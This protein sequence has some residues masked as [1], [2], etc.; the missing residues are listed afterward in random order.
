VFPDLI[1]REVEFC[2]VESENAP[3]L[4]LK[5]SHESKSREVVNQ[6]RCKPTTGTKLSTV[7]DW[8]LPRPLTM[9]TEKPA[10]A[11]AFFLACC[12]DRTCREA[13][14]GPG[15]SKESA[16]LFFDKKRATAG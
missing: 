4:R 3:E 12:R 10:V 11:V 9:S 15:V 14:L 1:A 5:T 13:P 16:R 7:E 8:S 6:S 2:Y